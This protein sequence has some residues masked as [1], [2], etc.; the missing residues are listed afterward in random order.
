METSKLPPLHG[1][2]LAKRCLCANVIMSQTKSFLAA[3]RDYLFD[4]YSKIL[5]PFNPFWMFNYSVR[6]LPI[7]L[8]T[9]SFWRMFSLFLQN[10][11]TLFE[12]VLA[13]QQIKN[14]KVRLKVWAKE[15]NSFVAC[16]YLRSEK[17]AEGLIMLLISWISVEKAHVN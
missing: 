12:A 9:Q 4:S 6:M 8:K 16:R 11:I 7:C 3:K 1:S 14:A 5:L 10:L 17:W 15:L 2:S 13:K